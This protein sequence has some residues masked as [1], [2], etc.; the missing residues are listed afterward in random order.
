MY[1]LHL[2]G[3][4]PVKPLIQ[5]WICIFHLPGSYGKSTLLELVLWSSSNLFLYFSDVSTLHI[6]TCTK[7]NIVETV[8]CLNYSEK[9]VNDVMEQLKAH[10]DKELQKYS[11]ELVDMVVSVSWQLQY[12]RYHHVSGSFE[13]YKGSRNICT[14]NVLHILYIL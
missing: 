13:Y 9:Q 5:W 3:S 4:C 10:V 12:T 7:L 6:G 1:L 8:I 2:L 11:D 14:V